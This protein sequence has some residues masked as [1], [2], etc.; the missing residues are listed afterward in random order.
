MHLFGSICQTGVVGLAAASGQERRR[1]RSG[2]S[3]RPSAARRR[4][5]RGGRCS[6]WVWP[7]GYLL[8]ARGDP[9]ASRPASGHSP[10][11]AA[12]HRTVE[13]PRLDHNTADSIASAASAAAQDAAKPLSPVLTFLLRFVHR[14]ASDRFVLVLEN[15]HRMSRRI[16]HEDALPAVDRQVARPAACTPRRVSSVIGFGRSQVLRPGHDALEPAVGRSR[17]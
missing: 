15:P 13:S 7:W 4:R 9:I 5:T 11:A 8:K 10:Q 3:R 17:P 12:G 16:E 6:D 1:G 2:R 14:V